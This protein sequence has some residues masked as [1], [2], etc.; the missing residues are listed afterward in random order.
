MLFLYNLLFFWGLGGIV[1]LFDAYY[2]IH[3]EKFAL[4]KCVPKQKTKLLDLYIKALPIVIRNQLVVGLI[5]YKY[6]F[7]YC[8]G[9]TYATWGKTI[10]MFLLKMI[11]YKISTSYVFSKSHKFYHDHM[12]WIH[13]RHHEF[14]TPVGIA[15]EYNSLLETILNFS[16]TYA[17]PYFLYFTYMEFI[18]LIFIINFEN[19]L[20][21]S[22]YKIRNKTRHHNWHHVKGDCNYASDA[23]V[24]KLWGTYFDG[25]T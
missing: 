11:M 5:L 18:I 16:Y 9:T 25:S 8:F 14:T 1:F 21:H 3:S 19:I 13:K 24:D 4:V 12:Y 6:E 2:I 17:V 15:A 7:I 22:G 23:F 20:N 10:M